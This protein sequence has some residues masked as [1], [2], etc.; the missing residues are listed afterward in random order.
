MTEQ[1][2]GPAADLTFRD[3]AVRDP[4]SP[5]TRKERL[6]L[7]AVSVI[8]IAILRTGLVPSKIATFGIVLD[9]P[10]RNALLFLLALVTVYF[11]G[12]FIIY[13]ASDYVTR[14]E[15][16]VVAREREETRARYEEVAAAIN[17]SEENLHRQYAQNT[18]DFELYVSHRFRALLGRERTDEETDMLAARTIEFL[19]GRS[20]E[21]PPRIQDGQIE[22][23]DWWY[24]REDSTGLVALTRVFFDLFLPPIVGLY[25]IYTLLYGALVVP[26]SIASIATFGL[27]GMIAA[28]VARL[29]F[30]GGMH[31]GII[32]DIFLC[33]PG[34][35]VGGFVANW[36]LV[37]TGVWGVNLT[38]IVGATLGAVALFAIP[39]LYWRLRGG[40]W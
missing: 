10:D 23:P 20:D 27:I 18:H 17:T 5:V 38:S 24:G 33:L 2:A 11:L 29:L 7:L 6:Y 3:V 26:E 14:R 34:A 9:K 40:Y 21:L 8:G 19:E 28:I 25:A 37:G 4:L 36:L 30:P 32:L 31:S 13:A 12:A 15:A 22:F 39:R 1:P 35:F 16:L